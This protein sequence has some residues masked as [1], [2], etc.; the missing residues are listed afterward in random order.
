MGCAESKP[1]PTTTVELVEKDRLIEQLRQQITHQKVQLDQQNMIQDH[2][3]RNIEQQ[4]RQ[5]EGQ[6][7][8]LHHQIRQLEQQKT[9]LTQQQRQIK[10]LEMQLDQKQKEIEV[11]KITNS[12]LPTP[13]IPVVVLP[14]EPNFTCNINGRNGYAY[15]DIY[16]IGKSSE[17]VLGKGSF[18][19]V[20]RA[21]HKFAQN[22][23]EERSEEDDELELIAAKRNVLFG[24]GHVSSTNGGIAGGKIAPRK[25]RYNPIDE[26]KGYVAIKTA[27]PNALDTKGGKQVISSYDDFENYCAEIKILIRLRGRNARFSPCLFLYEYFWTTTEFQMVTEVLG[28]ELDQWRNNHVTFLERDAMAAAKQILI[29]MEFM[30]G[31]NVVRK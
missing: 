13:K 16:E 17:D 11:L 29:A 27:E 8:Q 25:S 15:T 2:Q 12:S 23:C 14:D 24:P 21:K 1:N 22:L 3:R 28:Q 4:L 30:H 9:Q 6:Q 26:W 18:G 31:R 5:Q 7:G 20:Y 19:K 10:Q